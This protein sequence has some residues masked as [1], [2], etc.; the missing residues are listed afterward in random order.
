MSSQSSETKARGR[1]R[2]VAEAEALEAAMRVFWARG[3]TAASVEELTQATG[4]NRSSL[5][6]QWRDK[7]GLFMAAV[8]RYAATRLR[9]VAAALDTGATLAESLDAFFAAVTDLALDR[10]GGGGCLVSCALAEAAALD[11][12]LAQALAVRFDAVEERLAARIARAGP[13]EAPP[14]TD[15]AALAALLAAVARGMMLRARAGAGR[16]ALSAV[17]AMAVSLVRRDG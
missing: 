15:P 6:H 3:Y 12:D 17:G 16:G 13:G 11:P 1:P 10:D 8:E 7:R 2:R 14:G 4:L 5:Y 9:A